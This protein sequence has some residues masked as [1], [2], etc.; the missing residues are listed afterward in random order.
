M[1]KHATMRHLYK[2]KQSIVVNFER[3]DN[4]SIL[5]PQISN[6]KP[7][8]SILKSQFS[9]SGMINCSTS[10]STLTRKAPTGVFMIRPSTPTSARSAL[11]TRISLVR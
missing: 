6:L 9:Y 5:K 2:C 4:F 7:Q 1:K 10:C 8:F 3:S 11:S